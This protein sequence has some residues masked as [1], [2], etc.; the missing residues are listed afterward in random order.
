VTTPSD[1]RPEDKARLNGNVLGV[2]ERGEAAM[3]APEALRGW[4]NPL[5]R[6]QPVA[7]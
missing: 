7:R 6:P 5:D 3:E 1:L 2:A 4:L